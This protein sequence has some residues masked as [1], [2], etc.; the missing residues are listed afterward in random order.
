MTPS[1]DSPPQVAARTAGLLYVL[2]IALGLWS[3]VFVRSA[4]VVPGDPAATAGN[5]LASE[6]LFLL[7][8]AA[9]TGMAVSDVALAVLLFVLLRPVSPVLALMAMAFRLVQAAILGMN[10][11]NQHMVLLVLTSA[12]P[13]TGTG[14]EALALLFA[15]AQSHGY[16]LALIFFGVNSLLTGYLI[17]RSGYLPR[18]LGLL[19]AAAGLVYLAGSTLLFLT[20]QWSDLFAPAYLLP[21]VAETSLAGWLLVRGVGPAR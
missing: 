9:D 10:L 21:V 6:G 4:L 1:F 19:V 20:P 11:L 2:I 13:S 12:G 18:L 8:F 16:D 17:A 14:P 7:S 3:E 5:V 15:T